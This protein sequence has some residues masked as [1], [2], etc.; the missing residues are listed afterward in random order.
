MAFRLKPKEEKFFALLNEHAALCASASGLMRKAF[1]GEMEKEKA[2]TKI[3]A[4]EREADKLVQ[5]TSERL[6]KTFITPM[7][8]EDIQ[9]LI[10]QMDNTID[11]IKDIMDKMCMYRV[12]QPSGGAIALASIVEKSLIEIEKSISYMGS[13]KKNYE[14]LEDRVKKVLELEERGDVIY[15]E[16]MAYLFTECTDPIEIIKWKEILNSMEDVIDSCE[17]LVGTF[18]RVVLKYA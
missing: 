14:K 18:R 7:D 4:M 10:E 16:E 6:R 15:H 5:D 11:A 17:K 12:G 9:L 2:L 1:S 8:R 13:L 3:D